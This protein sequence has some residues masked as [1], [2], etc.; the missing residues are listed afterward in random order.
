MIQEQEIWV[1]VLGYEGRYE[2]SN[3]GRIKS[4]YHCDKKLITP[5]IKAIQTNPN[6]YKTITLSVNRR[7]KGFMVSRLVLAAFDKP[8]PSTIDCRHLDGDKSNNKLNNLKWG[9]RKENEADKLLHGTRPLGETNGASKM[10]SDQILK[11]RELHEQGLNSR[12]IADMFNSC[13]QNIWHII[14]R[15]TWK[16]I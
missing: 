16:H 15:K 7:V 9:T 12:Q 1:P 10:K 14:N 3:L 5:K 11:I 4:F 8:M 13:Q 6:G 2:V